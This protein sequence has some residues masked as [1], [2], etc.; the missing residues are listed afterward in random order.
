VGEMERD[1]ALQAIRRHQRHN[2]L[3]NVL[4]LTFYDLALSFIFGSTVLSLYTSYLTS[5]AFMIGLVPAIQNVGYFIPQLLLA[6]RAETLPRK[7]PFI[8]RISVMERLPYLIV[9]VLILL[10]PEA[11]SWLAY[12]VLLMS[13]GTATFSGGL[14]SPAWQAMIA[15][16]VPA[17]R[18]GLLFSLGRA[19]G[20][21]LGLLGALLSRRILADYAYPISFGLC[22]LLAF[23]AQACSWCS[24]AMN[25][26]PSMP[27]A[28]EPVP[29]RAYLARLP[30]L[31]SRDRN[32]RRYLM[33]RIL[34]IL[35]GM[36][37][38]FYVIYARRV[39]GVGDAFAG[40][41]TMAALAAQLTLVPFLG[42]LSGP[43]G[44]K[45]LA[46]LGSLLAAVGLVALLLAPSAAWLYVVFAIMNT[47][48]AAGGTASFAMTMEFCSEDEVPTYTAMINT[49]VAGPILLAPMLGGWLVDAA[50]F[51]ATFG[52]S[53][54]FCVLGWAA[55]HWLVRDP[56]IE[57][58][59]PAAE[60]AA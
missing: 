4:D 46:E 54:L 18:R 47:G 24:L 30:S 7:K 41:L 2:F 39:F 1:A 53:L 35:G 23:G 33:A 55:M 20:G 49:I 56:R 57:V 9:A 44:H 48:G 32:L 22:F 28:R 16:V 17:S 27:V 42:W 58:T 43:L 29:P 19:L 52:L 11:P 31:L 59:S 51:Q 15:K 10:W 34:T 38:A 8:M 13:L 21:G 3:V 26:E 12:L 40:E 25:R 6:Q 14:A 45:W 36:T 60:A 5:S 50:G 37:G